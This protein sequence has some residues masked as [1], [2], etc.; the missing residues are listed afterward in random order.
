MRLITLILL[1]MPLTSRR[2][3]GQFK[4]R[5]KVASRLSQRETEGEAMKKSRFSEEQLAYA[6]RLAESGTSVADVCR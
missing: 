5:G 2:I 4:T 6:L 3:R 1:L